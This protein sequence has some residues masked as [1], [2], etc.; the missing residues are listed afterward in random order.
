MHQGTPDRDNLLSRLSR[1]YV[2]MPGTA[3]LL[4][5][6]QELQPDLVI[7]GHGAPGNLQTLRAMKTYL[8]DL[9][10]TAQALHAGGIPPDSL[11]QVP[12]PEPYSDWLFTRFYHMN[13]SHVYGLYTPAD[14]DQPTP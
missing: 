11:E 3:T 13:L 6:L 5:A 10:N 12:V 2:V 9:Q 1:Q 8:L 14:G 7:P 4:D